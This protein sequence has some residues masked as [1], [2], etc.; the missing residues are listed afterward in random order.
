MREYIIKSTAFI[1]RMVILLPL[2]SDPLK[3]ENSFQSFTLHPGWKA[4][5]FEVELQSRTPANVFAGI[6]NLQSAWIWKP[7]TST[8]KLM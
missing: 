2:T 8:V 5:F 1:L 4:V 6:G 3:A 7:R